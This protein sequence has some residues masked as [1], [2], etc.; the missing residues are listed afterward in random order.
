[1]TITSTQH[2]SD[3]VWGADDFLPDTFV[4]LTVPLALY[5]GLHSV[6]SI[7][8]G[9]IVHRFRLRVDPAVKFDNYFSTHATLTSTYPDK[10]FTRKISLENDGRVLNA[11]PNRVWAWEKDVALQ[12]CFAHV[13]TETT[14]S[15]SPSVFPNLTPY[16]RFYRHVVQRVITHGSIKYPSVRSP[17]RLLLIWALDLLLKPEAHIHGSLHLARLHTHLN[18]VRGMGKRDVAR[19]VC[20]K[21]FAEQPHDSAWSADERNSVRSLG[22]EVHFKKSLLHIA[23]YYADEWDPVDAARICLNAV[24]P[25]EDWGVPGGDL[26]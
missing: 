24:Y 19:K 5:Y 2:H 13:L 10:S 3:Y 14:F 6:E 26:L 17:S 4:P 20:I 7:G 22:G 11:R 25:Q 8:Q 21:W 16:E 9:F 15:E 23:G 1:M 12:G 18:M